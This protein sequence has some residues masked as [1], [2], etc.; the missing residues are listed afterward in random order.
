MKHEDIHKKIDFEELM[1]C[2]WKRLCKNINKLLSCITSLQTNLSN[3]NKTLNEVIMNV[4]VLGSAMKG[5]VLHH[6]NC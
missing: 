3:R 1:L 5:W 4:D 6:S 2:L